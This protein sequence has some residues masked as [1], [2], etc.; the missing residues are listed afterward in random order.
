MFAKKNLNRAIAEQSK[1]DARVRRARRKNVD[2]R[3]SEFGRTTKARRS[4]AL[5]YSPEP[6]I[7][8]RAIPHIICPKLEVS[9]SARKIETTK[10]RCTQSLILSSNI[11]T[12]VLRALHHPLQCARRRIR[13]SSS[14]R[15]VELSRS[16]A[17]LR[18]ICSQSPRL[19][20]LNKGRQDERASGCVCCCRL[21][22][23]GSLHFPPTH[24]TKNNARTSII[25]W[26]LSHSL[27][28]I[29]Q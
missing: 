12:S 8:P 22:S 19:L 11:P 24:P 27:S 16:L 7:V 5:L 18:R 13:F 25:F 23:V 17:R 14:E 26:R 20:L 6:N 10:Q 4:V 3:E 1:D 21:S 15:R 9:A 2:G 29:R 28:P